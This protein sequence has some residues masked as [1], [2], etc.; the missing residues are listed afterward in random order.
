SVLAEEW[1][2]FGSAVAIILYA[3]L[4]VRL[5]NVALRSAEP[6]SSFVSVGVAAML[7]WHVVVNIGMVIGVMPVVG[8]T[9]TLLSY[10]GSSVITMMAALGI[11][12]GFSIRRFLFA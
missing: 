11:V 2:F 12:A 3:L 8:I 7:F 5:L 1:G 9:L 10:G 4:I 6:F